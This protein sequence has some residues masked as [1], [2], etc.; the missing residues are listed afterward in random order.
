M[1]PEVRELLLRS[2]YMS[3][4]S[5]I[6]ARVVRPVGCLTT[7]VLNQQARAVESE[8]LTET[9]IYRLNLSRARGGE[10]RHKGS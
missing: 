3:N 8:I 1:Q 5:S 2:T 7:G 10:T 4:E 6:N 9:G